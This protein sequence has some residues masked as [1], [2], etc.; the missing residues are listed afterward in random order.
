MLNLGVSQA[1]KNFRSWM[2]CKYDFNNPYQP[3]HL[4]LPDDAKAKLVVSSRKHS[5]VALMV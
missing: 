1:C 4:Q 3:D 2:T 5:E